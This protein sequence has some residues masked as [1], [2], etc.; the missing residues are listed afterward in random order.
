MQLECEN[1]ALSAA[2]RRG[3]T[4]ARHLLLLLHLVVS[5]CV[6]LLL[7]VGLELRLRFGC[8]LAFLLRLSEL[9]L[10]HEP[11]A[12]PPRLFPPAHSVSSSLTNVSNGSAHHVAKQTCW[13]Q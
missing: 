10:R 6:G 5:L 7:S 3:A 11:T 8:F 13:I 4:R 9:F 1:Q 12:S 2:G